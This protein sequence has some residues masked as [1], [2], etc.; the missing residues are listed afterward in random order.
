MPIRIATLFPFMRETENPEPVPC[1]SAYRLV[2]VL[3]RLSSSRKQHSAI[4]LVSR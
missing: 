2:P 3:V 4:L 1:G